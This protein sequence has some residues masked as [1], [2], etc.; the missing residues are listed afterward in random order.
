[1]TRLD[2]MLQPGEAV[3]WRHDPEFAMGPKWPYVMGPGILLAMLAIL[4]G[5]VLWNVDVPPRIL[6]LAGLVFLMPAL[7]CAAPLLSGMWARA[8]AVTAGRMVWR[9]GPAS[10]PSGPQDGGLPPAQSALPW[11]RAAAPVPGDDSG[12]ALHRLRPL[13]HPHRLW[14]PIQMRLPAGRIRAGTGAW[15]RQAD[16]TRLQPKTRTAG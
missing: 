4:G 11:R 10:V 7:F 15:S 9:S 12:P 13:G 5:V 16:M 2:A 3:V 6:L 8:V 14:R 1:M